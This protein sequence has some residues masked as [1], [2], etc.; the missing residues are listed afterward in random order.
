MGVVTWAWSGERGG[1]GGATSPAADGWCLRRLCLYFCRI[2]KDK[3]HIS[4]KLNVNSTEK[5]IVEVYTCTCTC[6]CAWC[7][8]H[9]QYMYMYMHMYYK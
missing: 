3:K 1:P 7:T 2:C 9:V 4:I 6:T 8:T 5:Y